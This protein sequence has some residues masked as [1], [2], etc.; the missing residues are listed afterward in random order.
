[1]SVV[2]DLRT[3]SA[4]HARHPDRLIAVHRRFLADTLTPVEAF[5]RLGG[6]E[7]G[8]LLESVERG[9]RIG[10]YSFVGAEPEAVFRGQ[11]LPEPR[12]SMTRAGAAPEPPRPGDPVAEIERYVAAN[13]ALPPD[14]AWGVPPFAGGAVGYLGYDIARLFEP[15]LA[16]RPPA[17]LGFPGVPD[18]LVPVYRTLLAFDHVKNVVFVVHHADPREGGPEAAH[19]R[20]CKTLDEVVAKLAT[21]RAGPL[22][23]ILPAAAPAEE[24]QSNL[25][26]AAFLKA[27][28]AAK[29]FIA[30]GDIIQAVLSQRF[31]RPTSAPP[32][33][34]YR[35]LRAVNPSPYMFYLRAP[36]V[37]LVGSSPEVMV[38]VEDGLIT[39]RPIAGTRPRG[40]SPEEDAALARE[41][42]ADE[43]ERAEHVML[44]DLGRNDVGRVS[45]FGSVHVTEEMAIENYSHVMHIVSNVEGR[46][47]EGRG[48]FDVLRA[49]HPAGTVSG[50]PKIRAMEIIDELE[51]DSRGPYAGAVGV[52]DLLGNLNTCIAIRTFVMRRRPDGR[53]DAH[54]QAGAGI[55]ADSVP[56]REFEETRNKARALLRSLDAAEARLA[57]K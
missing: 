13:R 34:V 46:M 4:L 49:C 10:R 31:T 35:S 38:R 45:N 27:V 25:E 29:E 21:P 20:A 16:R 41:L 6:S 24:V 2:P 22:S 19:A 15:R 17:K 54:V 53:W 28:E 30:A 18:V 55:V 47:T 51:P 57:K 26:R 40:K 37:H 32:F 39:V 52:I 23:E 50:A 12:V 1:M 5:A 44:L 3:F 9:E 48:A 33:E 14:P 42:L 43:K 11:V 7:Y 8:F 56:E 36:E